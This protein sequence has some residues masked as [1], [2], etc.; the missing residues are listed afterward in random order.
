MYK[1]PYGIKIKKIVL[2]SSVV[3]CNFKCVMENAIKIIKR[4]NCL[5]KWFSQTSVCYSIKLK[6]FFFFCSANL[7]F[8]MIIR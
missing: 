1:F 4:V 8:I 5:H 6:G 2:Y 7:V 3:N